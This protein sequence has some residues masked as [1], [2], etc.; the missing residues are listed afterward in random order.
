MTDYRKVCGFDVLKPG[1][2]YSVHVK[3]ETRPRVVSSVKSLEALL[4]KLVRDD[5]AVELTIKQIPSA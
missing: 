4:E 1:Y 2:L 5:P 3:G